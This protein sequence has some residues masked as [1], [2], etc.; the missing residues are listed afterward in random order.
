MSINHV[1]TDG[2]QYETKQQIE[3]I[4]SVLEYL[5]QLENNR[6]VVETHYFNQ[7]FNLVNEQIN[8]LMNGIAWIEYT[9]VLLKMNMDADEKNRLFTGVAEAI[10]QQDWLTILDFLSYPLVQYINLIRSAFTK[11]YVELTGELI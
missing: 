1:N 6:N 4:I 2:T 8:A 10:E 11:K 5:N 9:V 7:E 3:V